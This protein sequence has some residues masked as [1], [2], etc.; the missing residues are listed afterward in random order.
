M[1]KGT[2][3]FYKSSVA[4]MDSAGRI[5][6]P[7]EV[8]EQLGIKSGERLVMRVTERGHLEAW[9]TEWG[10][11]RAQEIVRQVVP[12]GVSMVD[13][14]IA[15]RRAENAKDEAEF[16]ESRRLRAVRERQANE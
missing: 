9:T 15:D 2:R 1:A 5:V 4:R 14:L 8:R 16:E 3:G 11:K 12:E 13:E 6:I 7:A 10:I